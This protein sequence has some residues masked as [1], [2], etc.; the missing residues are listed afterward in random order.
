M[1]PTL[2]KKGR[3]V[4]EALRNL[5]TSKGHPLS[6]PAFADHTDSELG[7]SGEPPASI[8]KG[9]RISL[10]A[11]AKAFCL[12][13]AKKK[14]VTA[15]DFAKEYRI[16]KRRV[17]DVTNVL[18]ALNLISYTFPKSK[19]YQWNGP[20]AMT[21]M[22]KD[23]YLLNTEELVLDMFEQKAQYPMQQTAIFL[24]NFYLCGGYEMTGGERKKEKGAVLDA[25]QNYVKDKGLASKHT[26]GTAIITMRGGKKRETDF[27]FGKGRIVD[28]KAHTAYRRVYDVIN[29]FMS[30]G[31]YKCADALLASGK[32][33]PRPP[34]FVKNAAVIQEIVGSA[35][36]SPYEPKQTSGYCRIPLKNTNGESK[37]SFI[38]KTEY[39]VLT[40]I[41]ALIPVEKKKERRR[42]TKRG[43][44]SDHN[45]E[46]GPPLEDD[47][48]SQSPLSK[49]SGRKSRRRRQDQVAI[50]AAAA[51]QEE[52]EA[53]VPQEWISLGS[54]YSSSYLDDPY[55]PPITEGGLMQVLYTSHSDNFEYLPLL[56]DEILFGGLTAQATINA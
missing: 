48:L 50:S 31:F 26:K 39:Q 12:A 16:A 43:L 27:F 21:Q 10:Q 56:D 55:N 17:Y 19:V 54:S 5:K 30:A 28:T 37:L 25:I 47:T 41:T 23:T 20:E 40:G 14:E 44:R 46:E 36:L 38:K 13:I 45:E 3:L 4:I 22:C 32:L 6:G 8:K 18:V 34:P 1:E 51:A 29:I 35:Q 24:A 33:G 11:L 7:V 49:I 15:V 42:G 2:G 53:G 9:D 52:A